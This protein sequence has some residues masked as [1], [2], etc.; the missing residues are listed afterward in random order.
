MRYAFIL[1]KLGEKQRA[2]SLLTAGLP[3]VQ[4]LPRIGMRGHGIR[5]VQILALQGKS[6]E[7]LTAMRE[8]IDEGFRG[9]VL[10]N[11]WRLTIDP[12]LASLRD[13][14]EFQAMVNEIDDAIAV[15]QNRVARAEATGDWDA[16]R[17]LTDSS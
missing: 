5:D 13:K 3:V 11:G 6:F 17:A 1:Q 10:T 4:S 16:L 7:A 8:A 12:Y 2:E 9:T 15:M 14:P